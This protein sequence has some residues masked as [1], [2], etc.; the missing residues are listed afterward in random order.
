MVLR[1]LLVL[2]L[3][4]GTQATFAKRSKKSSL[5]QKA[6]VYHAKKQYKKSNAVFRK[7]ASL[8]A[9]Q[10]ESCFPTIK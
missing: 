7:V 5:I 2:T 10:F 4:I 3:L 6:K 9:N 1:I 8:V